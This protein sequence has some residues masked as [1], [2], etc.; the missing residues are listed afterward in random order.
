MTASRP[1]KPDARRRQAP[2]C[3]ND[4]DE[5]RYLR[6]RYLSELADWLL[7]HPVL[8]RGR[9]PDSPGLD[10]LHPGMP[11]PAPGEEADPPAAASS[12][13]DWE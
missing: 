11:A 4:P 12:V 2:A 7:N 10:P 8:R 13:D 6:S 3:E 9:L 1:Q 5:L